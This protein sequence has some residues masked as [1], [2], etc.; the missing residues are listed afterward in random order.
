MAKRLR[1]LASELWETDDMDSSPSVFVAESG[2]RKGELQLENLYLRE[3]VQHLQ[4]ELN[5]LQ[6]RAIPTSSQGANDVGALGGSSKEPWIQSLRQDVVHLPRLGTEII[7]DLLESGYGNGKVEFDIP[8]NPRASASH[9]AKHVVDCVSKLSCKH[10]AVFK[11]GITANP[12][13]RWK[14]PVYGYCLDRREKWQG[15]K[16]V[17]VNSSSFS[18]ALL[19]SFMISKFK[20]NL[21]CRNENPGGES[22]C[23]GEGPHFTYVVYRV[24]VPPPR[25]VSK[26]IN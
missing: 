26:A 21:G 14:H 25:V 17:S 5:A 22:A 19:E 3:Q 13:K 12:I 15:M 23:P 20:G 4:E 18:A 7:P 8:K 11:I 6:T 2:A 24:L 10:P 16:V 1:S 9:V